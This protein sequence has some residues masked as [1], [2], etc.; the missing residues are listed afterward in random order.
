MNETWL[1]P[2]REPN[3]IN[4]RSFFNHR[5]SST[6][7]GLLTLVRNDLH[8]MLRELVSYDEGKLEIQCITVISNNYKIDIVNVYNPNENISQ[9]E[10]NHY[11][12]QLNETYLI[13]G[14]FNAHHEMWDDRTPSNSSGRNLVN[15]VIEV[16]CSL[17]TPKNLPTHYHLQTNSFSTLDLVFLSTNLFNI[18]EISLEDDLDSDHYPVLIIIAIK[19]QLSGQ[20]RRPKW[21]FEQSL[22]SIWQNG[23]PSLETTNN[24]E[25]D[26]EKFTCALLETGK[27]IFKVTKGSVNIKYSKP[28]WNSDCEKAVKE[29]HKAKNYFKNHPTMR[30]YEIYRE[31]EKSSNKIIKSAKELSFRDFIN[32]IKTET[33]VSII[34]KRISCLSNKYKPTK[35]IPLISNQELITDPERKVELIADQYKNTFNSVAKSPISV[36]VLMPVALSIVDESYQKYNRKI[37]QNEMENALMSLKPTSPGMDMIHNNFLKNL[38]N[39]Y[40]LFLLNLF[41]NIFDTGT[42]P[43]SWKMALIIPIPKP[44]KNLTLP[45]SY[46]PISLLSGLGKLLEKILCKRLNHFIEQNGGFSFTQGG[47][48]KR[49]CTLDQ[50]ARLEFNIRKTMLDK[51]I[52]MV[53]F[54]DLSQAY[55]RVWHAG[56]LYKLQKVGIK[57]KLLKYVREYLYHRNFKVYFDGEYSKSHKISSGVP[58]GSI[59]SPLLFN[60]MMNDIP[61]LE[62]VNLMEYADDITFYSSNTDLVELKLNMQN[63]LEKLGEWIKKWGLKLNISKTKAMIFTNK[64]NI[65]PPPIIFNGEHIKF[66]PTHMYLGVI[67][68]APKLTW[69]NQIE[70]LKSSSLSRINIMKTL[71][72][73]QWG[74]DKLTLTKIYKSLVRSRFD[75]GSIFYGTASDIHLSKLDKLQNICLRLILGAQKTSPILSLEVECNIPPLKIHRR[76][77]LMRNFCRMAELPETTQIKKDLVNSKRYLNSNW[78]AN[79]YPP[80][81]LRAIKA[82]EKI[83]INLCSLTSIP[84]VSPLPPWYD[85]D[86]IINVE[87]AHT[88]VRLIT[89]D[90]AQAIF[91]DLQHSVYS[92]FMEIYTDGSRI[93]SPDISCAAG[94]VIKMQNTSIMKNYKLPPDMTIMG[95]ELFAI[96]Q[97]LLFIQA[98]LINFKEGEKLFVIFSD[99]LSGILALKNQTPKIQ[100]QLVIEI[101]EIL[102][103]LPISINIKIQFIPAHKNISGNELADL[104]ANAAH[105]NS[106]MEM[107]NLAKEDKVR[108]IKKSVLTVWQD[109]WIRM[110]EV[111]GKGKFLN[112]IRSQIG[113]WP[114]SCHKVRTIETVFS[115]LRIGHVN[116]NAHRYRF[117]LT[118]SLACRCGDLENINHIFISCP[119]HSLQR[120]ILYDELDL[121]GVPYS[122][123]NLLG[124]GDFDISKQIKIINLTAKFLRDIKKL[125]IL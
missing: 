125:Y 8:C 39:E 59:L 122:I 74:A 5:I 47:F 104:A 46:R 108:I 93:T 95:C 25:L 33:P 124:G 86:E 83:N 63:Q 20:K 101:H 54:V 44:E 58:Q 68:D 114:W 40:K 28:W 88:S 27:K 105:A 64:R 22:W 18:S 56:L 1:K 61:R 62:N 52:C 90:M 48:R 31:K 10:F 42:I 91:K 116:T 102:F 123:K 94:I 60:I 53:I 96:K 65:F 21:I 32:G 14:D 3:F 38:T 113:F 15:A 50:L 17:L 87:F 85:L 45:E 66:V 107:V 72:A 35:L 71:S 57:G 80:F 120:T 84:L 82:L 115:K 16:N 75:Y 26:A 43:Q 7:G 36:Q 9:D 23:L 12:S 99:S 6:G 89:D 51:Q 92:N 2:D 69:K 29:K 111:T 30:N 73:K 78:S 81:F 41:N 70:F 11:F 34:W 37:T 119:L 109:Y 112:T 76:L 118:P 13:C 49:M 79:K 98:N 117:Q 4:Y 110:I 67:F 97:A 55:D 77:I 106:E 103:N 121:L 19:P 100:L 24:V